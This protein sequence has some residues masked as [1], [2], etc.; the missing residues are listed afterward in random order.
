MSIKLAASD[1]SRPRPGLPVKGA[2]R[3]KGSHKD[4]DAACAIG[5]DQQPCEGLR[6]SSEHACWGGINGRMLSG[7]CKGCEHGLGSVRHQGTSLHVQGD[8]RPGT[9]AV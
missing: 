7:G 3:S 6:G 4:R 9:S 2:G 8:R 1:A 5:L